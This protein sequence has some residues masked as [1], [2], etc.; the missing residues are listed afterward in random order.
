MSEM[1][2][3]VFGYVTMVLLPV[4]VGSVY[5]LYQMRNY[6]KDTN[7]MKKNLERIYGKEATNDNTFVI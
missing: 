2:L 3:V 6:A 4:V 5:I 7:Q 1:N